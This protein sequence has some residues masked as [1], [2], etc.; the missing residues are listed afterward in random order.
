[1]DGI[2]ETNWYTHTFTPWHVCGDRR[3]VASESVW[4]AMESLGRCAAKTDERFRVLVRAEVFEYWEDVMVNASGHELYDNRSGGWND[5]YGDRDGHRLRLTMTDVRRRLFDLIDATPD[6]D[7]LLPTKQPE[8][9]L[10]MMPQK[11]EFDSAVS[12]DI[13]A[14]VDTPAVRPNVWLGTTVSGPDDLWRIPHLL[15]VPSAVRFLS[16]EPLLGPVDLSRW[17]PAGFANWQCMK[18]QSFQK[19]YTDCNHCHAAKE[20]LC[21]SHVANKRCP[22][23]GGISGW[24]N[25]QPIDW[26]IVGGE[27]GNGA[28]PC[29]VDWV[30]GIVRECQNSGTPVFVKQLGAHPIIDS[31][32]DWSA[33][34]SEWPNDPYY[35]GPED[36]EDGP[37]EIYLHNPKGADPAEWPE[38]L[39]VREVPSKP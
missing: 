29:N 15:K 37:L 30:R 27:S 38:D 8:N 21:G 6:L 12:S 36:G 18:C 13:G 4:R 5:R 34:L 10:A 24:V 22:V 35:S 9:V 19:H 14:M 1:M 26:V 7:W 17:I 11:W 33:A 39:R 2:T 16:C 31:R 20:C 23:M 32:C 28:R 3:V 25:R